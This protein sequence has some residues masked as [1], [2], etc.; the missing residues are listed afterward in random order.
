MS[1]H[2]RR[3]RE[4]PQQATRCLVPSDLSRLAVGIEQNDQRK[5][6]NHHSVTT[7]FAR[8]GDPSE[9]T[10]RRDRKD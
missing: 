7:P 1:H 4:K 10:R 9:C 3:Q 2:R 5:C 8:E 6:G